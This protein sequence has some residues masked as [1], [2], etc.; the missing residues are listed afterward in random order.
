MG[1]LMT[2]SWSEQDLEK[3]LDSDMYF[4]DQ[5]LK[6]KGDM[7][8]IIFSNVQKSIADLLGRVEWPDYPVHEPLELISNPDLVLTD[9]TQRHWHALHLR[10]YDPTSKEQ[11]WTYDPAT[12]LLTN[13]GTGWIAV[14]TEKTDEGDWVITG[15]INDGS[16]PYRTWMMTKDKMIQRTGY[17]GK[18][19]TAS[20]PIKEWSWIYMAPPYP[21]APNQQF[22]TKKI[23]K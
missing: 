10:K 16:L 18:V 2:G 22:R 12:N 15:D 6:K 1:R 14:A 5:D 3:F 17:Q 23:K 20:M 11:L 8:K 9:D 19:I 7:G 13:D 21:G 4:L